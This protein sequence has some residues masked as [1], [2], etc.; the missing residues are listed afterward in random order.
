LDQI[1][2][3]VAE[4]RQKL[5]ILASTV[6]V[7]LMALSVANAVLFVIDNLDDSTTSKA[8]ASSPAVQ[9]RPGNSVNVASLN[10][11]GV[12]EAEDAPRVI[13]A[14]QTSLNLELQ[15]VFTA[16]D[17]DES[18]AIVAERNKAGELYQIGDRLPGNAT[19]DAVFDDHILIKRGARLEKLMFSDAQVRQQFS[20]NQISPSQSSETLSPPSSTR[21]Q[22]LR[23]RIE[24]RRATSQFTPTES[25]ASD[26]LRARLTSY[27]DQLSEDPQKVLNE[28][29]IAPVAQGEASGYR[30]AGEVP[31]QVLNQAG[32]QRGD[33]VL[34]VNGTP[35]GNVGNDQAL[36]DQ[37]LAAGRVRVEIQ[38]NDRKFYLT[39]PIP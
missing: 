22:N 4:H 18:T 5:A 1:L 2:D 9:T 31:E 30:I 32:L 11:F 6:A 33:V 12:A 37:A 36:I 19:L 34:S 3:L 39:V 14:P 7:V 17:P 35:V 13:D 23:E 20:P 25:P 28:I 15:G 8:G 21:L 10:L 29:G 38:R 16:A 27:R 24:A 26:S